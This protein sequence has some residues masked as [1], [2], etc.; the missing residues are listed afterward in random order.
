MRQEGLDVE[1]LNKAKMPT[2]SIPDLSDWENFLYKLKH[3]QSEVTIGLVGKY[4]ELKDAYKSINESFVHANAANQC[5]VNLKLINSEDLDDR[6]VKN[7]LNGL[8]GVLVAPGF[9]YRGIDGKITAIKYTR[10]NKVP[11][12]GI[13]LGM[14]CAVVEFARNVLGYKDAHSTEMYPK[15]NHPV[16]DLMEHQKKVSEKGG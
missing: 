6:N 5:K 7:K 15:T 9:G 16:I 8:N 3:P 10:E 14:Q 2:D 11:F 4:T 1:V 13:C 12:L